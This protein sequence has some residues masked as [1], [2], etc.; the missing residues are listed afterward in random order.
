MKRSIMFVGCLLYVVCMLCSCRGLNAKNYPQ[1]QP[2]TVWSTED[3]KM[4]F[5]LDEETS[6]VHGHI[7]TDEGTVDV[8]IAMNWTDPFVRITHKNEYYST[9]EGEAVP[10]FARWKKI[11]VMKD[12]ILVEVL[13]TVY[14][15]PGGILAFHKVK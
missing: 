11:L 10:D 12:L 9:K 1:N 8:V 3:G 13:D 7:M 4:I 5:Y 14:F 15:K 2:G 6:N